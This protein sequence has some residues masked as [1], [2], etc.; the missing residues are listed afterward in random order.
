MF[1]FAN[2]NPINLVLNLALARAATAAFRSIL[3]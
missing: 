3:R 1:I 2:D